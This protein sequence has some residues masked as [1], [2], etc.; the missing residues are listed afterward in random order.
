MRTEISYHNINIVVH[1]DE[2]ML[3]LRI[4]LLFFLLYNLT[5]GWGFG[6]KAY[7]GAKRLDLFCGMGYGIM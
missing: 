4:V 6:S 1:C 5:A 2:I 3:L 7:F